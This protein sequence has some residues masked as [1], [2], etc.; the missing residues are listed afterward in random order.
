MLAMS[1]A[2]EIRKL[3]IELL[4][5]QQLI[6]RHTDRRNRVHNRPPL[7]HFG[8]SRCGESCHDNVLNRQC[9]S[10]VRAA[11]FTERIGN[12]WNNLRGS[13]VNSTT[14]LPALY[15][16]PLC[17]HSGSLWTMLRIVK[18]N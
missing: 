8:P 7:Q 5:L 3:V 13:L 2:A 16:C 10:T 9:I 12:V 14:L 6:H 11:F 18:S 17:Q 4:C 15:T 1:F